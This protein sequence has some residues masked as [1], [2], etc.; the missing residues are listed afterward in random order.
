[1]GYC[2]SGRVGTIHSSE[3]NLDRGRVAAPGRA[4]GMCLLASPRHFRSLVIAPLLAVI[5]AFPASAQTSSD[6]NSAG[7][8]GARAQSDLTGGL[9][10]PI[11]RPQKRAIPLSRT[12]R[13][14]L[15]PRKPNLSPE[16]LSLN[17]ILEP[18]RLAQSSLSTWG[19]R[20]ILCRTPPGRP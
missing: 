12:Q 15:R 18:K 9:P 1:M 7:T 20:L 2:R 3:A 13:P 8:A 4:K 5:L 17:P 11:Q 14:T 10:A 16:V 6:S 19:V